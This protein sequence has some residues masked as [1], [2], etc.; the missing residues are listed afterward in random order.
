MAILDDTKLAMRI[1]TSAY[2][3]EIVSLIG[4][5]QLDLGVAGVVVPAELDALVTRAI[6]TYCRMHFGT[7][8]DYEHLKASYDEQK[9]QLSVHTGYTDWGDGV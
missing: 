4:A 9:A 7:P 6:V 8:D 2:D 1:V 5:A 3:A